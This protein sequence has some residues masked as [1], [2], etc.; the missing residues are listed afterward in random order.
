MP[1]VAAEPPD[2]GRRPTL[3]CL[4]PSFHPDTTPTAIRAGKLLARLSRD[5][6]VTV[7]SESAGPHSAGRVRVETVP[8]RRPRRLL[9]T[10]RR[11][12]LDK[13]LELLVW[14]DESIFWVRPAIRT[15][16]RLI[17]ARRPEAIVVF[18][19]PYGG[20]LAGLALSRLTGVPLVLN[21]DDSP[22]CTDMHPRFPSRLHH[23]LAR[24][25]E[26]LYV[27]RAD[28]VVYVSARNLA[29]VR[30]RQ[31]E[32][33]RPRM[34][35]VRYGADSEDFPSQPQR[36]GGFEIAYAGAMSGW[37]SLLEEEPAGG[38]AARL[39]GAWTRLGRYE[40]VELDQRTSS[41]AVIGRAILAASAR[42]PEWAE[43]IRLTVHGN[44]YPEALVSRAL[45]S[46][47]VDG[48]VEVL[49]PVPHG[50]V[51]ATL[52]RADLLFLT[53]PRR[54]DGSPGGRISAKTYEY[55]ATDRPILAGA[56]A[57]E[58]WDYLSGKPG[59][60]LVDPEDEEGMT[61]VIEQLAGAKFSGKPPTFDRAALHEELSYE[62]RAREFDA[63]I[64]E[65]IARRS[66]ARGDGPPQPERASG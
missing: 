15:G 24:R 18:M 32:A 57:G 2:D 50:E 63:V 66:A 38:L 43:E 23:R 26:D 56:P 22:T 35:L 27:R 58:N 36:P 62:T 3:L 11:L 53:L 28:A 7:L 49:G 61:D 37:W 45:A 48:V 51:A 5:W 20:G 21:L 6:D 13:L 29:Q 9:S 10:L 25:L 40:L 39:Y 1:G 47:G 42:H 19:M 52:A 65:A 64:R 59:V 14:P 16:R 44:P 8:S 55:L 54:V 33:V 60:W 4:S 17:S 41:P 12:R 30:A 34:H 31:A 46:A